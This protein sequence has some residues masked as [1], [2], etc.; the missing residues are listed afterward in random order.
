MTVRDSYPLPVIAHLLNNLHGCSFL[1]K[2]DLKAAFNLLRV[3]PG[4]EWKTAFRTP[5]GLYKYQVMPFGLANAPATFQR[6]IQHVLREYLDV[7]CFVYIVDILIFSRTKAQHLTDLR[8]ILLKLREYS[9]KASLNKCEFFC[10]QV[11][12]LGF[13]ITE[14][15]LKMNK[16]KLDTIDKWP[17]PSSLRELRRFLGF[18][19]FYRRFIPRFSAVAGALTSLTKGEFTEQLALHT[20]EALDSF[21]RLK[22][23]F[24]KEPLLLHFDFTKD[25]V[26]H[27]DSS[28]FAIA[29]VLSQPDGRGNNLPV[30]YFSRKLNERERSWQIFDLELLAIVAAFEEWRVWLMGTEN[31]VAVYSDHA[32]LLYFKTAKFLSPKQARWANYLDNFNMQIFHIVGSKNPAD[33]PSRREDFGDDEK[34]LPDSWSIAAKMVPAE[35]VSAL[36]I[37]HDLQF[38]RPNENL[39][40][41]FQKA[42]TPADLADNL[43]SERDGFLWHGDRV[44]VLESLRVRVVKMYH[45]APTVGHPGSAR[46]LSTLTRSFSWPGVRSFILAYVKSCDSC[47]RVKARRQAKD[48]KLVPLVAGPR[49]WSMIGMDMITKLPLSGGFDSILVVIDLL[50]K[51]THFIACKE[52]SSSMVLAGLFRKNVF[53]LH[54]LPDKI[55]SDRGSTFVSSIWKCLMVLLNIRSALS[56][57]YH[58]QTDGQTER[59][60]QVLEDYLRHFCSYY[61]DN[62]DKCLDMAEFSINNVDS[63]SLGESPFFF[64]NGHHPKFN[65][66]TASIGRKPLDEFLV[67]LQ[68]VQ[69]TAMECLIQARTRQAKYY[70]ANK[71][72]SPVYEPGQEVL[73]L[74]KFIKTRRLNSKLDYRYLGPFKVDKM[75]GKN[76]VS[77]LISKEFPKLHPVFNIGLVVPY[78]GPNSLINRGTVEGIKEHYYDSSEIVDWSRLKSILDVRAVRKDK[79]EYLL[80]WAESTVGDDTWVSEEHLPA[81]LDRYLEAFKVSY[82]RHVGKIN[83]KV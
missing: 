22:M 29:A 15:G 9:L 4:H 43:L 64:C 69:E 57:A 80:S 3:A 68:L 45:D 7:C 2:I 59:M 19:N 73:L 71:K 21:R 56:T 50:S 38:L 41:Y 24:V 47:Q 54:G 42:Y 31:P 17:F 74:R 39:L 16:G 23:L 27:V 79:F 53:R 78:W 77:L 14:Q 75:I 34:K 26:L 40:A 35:E 58:P 76:A 63:A 25:R 81:R 44:F 11:T 6:F 67:D 33:A 37:F 30:S 83:K 13:D 51:M 28:G 55:V 60:N 62:W 82:A 61:Q 12:F 36:S 18:T 66:L 8:N 70:N 52:A 65:I 10:T 46:T 5:W 20:P 32:N 72:E 49:P 48:G 1:S